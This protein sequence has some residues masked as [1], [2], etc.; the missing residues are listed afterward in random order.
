MRNTVHGRY[1]ESIGFRED[2]IFS[3]RIDAIPIVPELK[4]ANVI[5]STVPAVE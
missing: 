3:A 2:I 5:G 1:L 4:D